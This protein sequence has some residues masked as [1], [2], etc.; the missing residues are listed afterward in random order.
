[1]NEEQKLKLMQK[2]QCEADNYKRYANEWKAK[3]CFTTFQLNMRYAHGI[4]FAIDQIKR[5]EIKNNV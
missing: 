3:D 5:M 4:E 1:M 2:L